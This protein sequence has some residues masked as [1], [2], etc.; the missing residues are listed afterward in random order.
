MEEIQE[1]KTTTGN[2]YGNGRGAG[3][4]V[5]QLEMDYKK[6]TIHDSPGIFY[7]TLTE[8]T[9]VCIHL[10]EHDERHDSQ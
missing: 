5:S 9:L 3:K 1:G 7:S 4:S 8:M 6:G 2:V 10:F